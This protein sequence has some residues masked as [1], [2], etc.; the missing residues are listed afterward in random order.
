MQTSLLF[1]RKE[2]NLFLAISLTSI[3]CKL[4]EH[5]IHSYISRHLEHYNILTPKQH[6]FRKQHSCVSLNWFSLSTTGLWAKDIENNKQID[7]AI[8]DFTK[9]FDTVPHER[10]KSKLHHY[11]I[12]G[13]LLHWISTFLCCRKQRVVL[14][15]S[16]SDWDR[17]ESGVP[18]GT[19]LG[20]LLFLLY[21]NDIG[22]KVSSE[23][24][25]FADD[26]IVYRPIN[27]EV[28]SIEL[29]KDIKLLSD[30]SQTW[31]MSFNPKKCYVLHMGTKRNM[32]K[33]AYKMYMYDH[34]LETVENH[35]YLG[36]YISHNLK[37]DY[38]FECVSKKARRV[39]GILQRNLRQCSV[40]TKQ[41]AYYGLVRPLLEYAVGVT[42][43][44]TQKNVK[45]LDKIQ[46][47][48]ARF[49]TN[50][51]NWRDSVTEILDE[52]EW[53]SLSLRREATRLTLFKQML[54]GE[55]AIPNSLVEPHPCRGGRSA[56]NQVVAIPITTKD[57]YKFSFIP[58]TIKS[59]NK[60][61]NF[62]EITETEA[63]KPAVTEHLRS[64]A[65]TT[66]NKY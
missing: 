38:H 35:Q 61:P 39:L 29:Q 49:C 3:S 44:Y 33:H 57:I 7:I 19:V 50:N 47:R 5:I 27:N 32:Y 18:Q 36:I 25:L 24:R 46:R 23:I 59:W 26:C 53:D 11:G 54:T 10:L 51:Y 40:Q 66:R 65:R 60:L 12:R 13:R 48:A 17:V 15:G 42:D 28:D 22:D 58:R 43:P 55:T 63:F 8:F 45:K 37:W 31:Q 41:A 52:L 20:P 21:I 56:H 34:V 30:W 64:S 6:G 9:A 16:H 62:V 2:I 14:N 1:S 4:L